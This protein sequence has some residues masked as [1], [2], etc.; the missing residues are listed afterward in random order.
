MKNVIPYTKECSFEGK[1]A[2]I[3]SI[4]LEHNID[5]ENGALIGNFQI[6]GDYKSHEVS[7][8]KEPF[9]FNLP[10]S[11]ELA[12]SATRESV[13]FDIND[14]NYQLIND[15]TLK[16]D[17]EFSVTTPVI[18]EIPDERTPDI[19]ETVE[20][21]YE[22]LYEKLMSESES[23]VREAEVIEEEAVEEKRED[24]VS[25][26]STIVEAIKSDEDSYITYNVHIARDNE[27]IET[28][29]SMYSCEIEILSKYNDLSNITIGDKIIIPAL[30]LDE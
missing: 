20:D 24:L 23:V 7:L 28:I 21:E 25:A 5:V 1:V 14:F 29:S 8:N 12:D 10:F 9:E 3:T 22:D 18:E 26:E 11:I 6:T 15:N 17:I 30:V 4:S 27:T 13:E 2:E 19:F 16:V